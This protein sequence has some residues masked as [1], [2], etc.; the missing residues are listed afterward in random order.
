M[1]A[2]PRETPN[3]ST[4]AVGVLRSGASIALCPD[5]YR[6]RRCSQLVP[7]DIRGPRRDCSRPETRKRSDARHRGG[8]TATV[9]GVGIMGMSRSKPAPQ[10]RHEKRLRVKGITVR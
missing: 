4:F 7:V 3:A 10:R 9:R 2:H 1:P 8:G 6:G 5:R